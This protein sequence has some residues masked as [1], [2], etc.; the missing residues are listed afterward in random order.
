[1]FPGICYVK[2]IQMSCTVVLPHVIVVFVL[3][4]HHPGRF[5][6]DN[7]ITYQPFH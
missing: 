1:M 3:Y 6:S 4:V 7:V 5:E 2:Y